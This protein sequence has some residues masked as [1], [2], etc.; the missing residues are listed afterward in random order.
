M[1]AA[2][3][4]EIFKIFI[5][6]ASVSIC[7][8]SW[9]IFCVSFMRI[10]FLCIFLT[11]LEN[12][13]SKLT[14]EFPACATCEETGLLCTRLNLWPCVY[15]MFK[16]EFFI[17]INYSKFINS[18]PFRLNILQRKTFT[19]IINT[20]TNLNLVTL[21]VSLFWCY[22]REQ[23]VDWM[24]QPEQIKCLNGCWRIQY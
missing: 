12:I 21:S 16:F 7:I 13:S 6:M 11:I 22:V 14:V 15:F 1:I 4:Y 20:N 23:L 8:I 10:N 3:D 24:P 5:W 19:M 17:N 9:Y 18:H 2:I